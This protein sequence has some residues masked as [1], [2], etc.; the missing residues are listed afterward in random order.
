MPRQQG[1][2]IVYLSA[3]LI[4]RFEDCTSTLAR[5][6]P[7]FVALRHRYWQPLHCPWC[8]DA[9]QLPAAMGMLGSVCRLL[10]LIDGRDARYA[11]VAG[12][13]HSKVN[14]D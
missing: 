13:R 7:R 14:Y 10:P 9:Q 12:A 3:G 8:D 6:L 4:V 1:G 5:H 2:G 11:Q